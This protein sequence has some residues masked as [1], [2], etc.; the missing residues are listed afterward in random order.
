M[1]QQSQANSGRIN[2]S[3]VVKCLIIG[4]VICILE[5]K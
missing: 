1:N 2:K 3:E 5:H 4:V